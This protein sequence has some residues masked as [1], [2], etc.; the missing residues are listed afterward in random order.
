MIEWIVGI[1]QSLHDTAIAEALRESAWLF[2]AVETAHVLALVFVFGSIARLDLRLMGLVQRHRAVTE[3]A[4]EM[5]PYTWVSFVFAAIFGLLLWVSKPI[6]YVE[7]VFFDVKLILMALAG[8]NMLYFQ[9]VTLKT[10]GQWDRAL[11]PPSS[12][13]LAGGMSMAFWASV[14]VCG[15][16]MGFV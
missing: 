14:V 8:L 16:F 9:V 6:V 3:I 12:A 1:L 7:M 10:V 11:I 5:L 13:R 2:P 4:E 15:R